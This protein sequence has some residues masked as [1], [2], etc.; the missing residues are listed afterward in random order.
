MG[1]L[2]IKDYAESRGITHQAVYKMLQTHDNEL[3]EHILKKGN[4][5]FLDET[6]ASILDEARS[7]NPVV[8]LDTNR[9]E[10]I[11]HL[12][13]ENKQLLMRI[14]ELQ[15]EKVNLITESQKYIALEVK[16]EQ[17]AELIN[18]LKSELTKQADEKAILAAELKDK[19]A[20]LNTKYTET[21]ILTLKLES[22]SLE[23]VKL[24]EKLAVIQSE[25]Q[26]AKRPK[27][28]FARIFN[29]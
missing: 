17:D 4:T 6:A 11:E 24:E 20:D 27:G 9:D 15:N 28:L 22:Q 1:V 25:L 12:T 18:F 2:S 10:C 21:E 5:R 13:N 7:N 8:I 16:S 14:V 23:K 29:R 3:S 26:E 19:E